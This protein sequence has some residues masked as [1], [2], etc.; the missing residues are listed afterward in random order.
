[1]QATQTDALAIVLG[2]PLMARDAAGKLSCKYVLEA[3][4]TD[5]TQVSA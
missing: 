5:P 1:M 2:A 3:Y 4:G